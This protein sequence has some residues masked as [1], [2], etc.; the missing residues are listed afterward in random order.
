MESTALQDLWTVEWS[1]DLTTGFEEVDKM[2]KRIVNLAN[3]L[4]KAIIIPGAKEEEIQ[5]IAKELE[6]N[7]IGHFKLES[8]IFKKY[9]IEDY[10][11]HMGLHEEI[12]NEVKRINGLNLPFLVKTLMMNQLALFYIKTH[13]IVEDKACIKELNDKI[14]KNGK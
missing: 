12:K 10:E 11:R 7:L 9:D 2:H 1:N 3:E 13:L 14:H 4:Y 5:E 8:E 6:Y